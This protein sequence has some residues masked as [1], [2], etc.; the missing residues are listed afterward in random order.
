MEL[1]VGTHLHW[2]HAPPLG[3]VP[4]FS[5]S[6]NLSLREDLPVGPSQICRFQSLVGLE[7]TRPL[8]GELDVQP[9]RGH[10]FE[11]GVY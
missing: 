1:Y 3:S 4:V 6:E 11:R 8:M 2:R 5:S 9:N 7:L 10:S